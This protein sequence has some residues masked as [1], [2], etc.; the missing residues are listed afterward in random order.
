MSLLVTSQM[1]ELFLN[2][3]TADDKYSLHNIENLQ[4]PIQLH[5]SKKQKTFANFFSPI[6]KLTSNFE[7]FETKDDAHRLCIFEIMDCKRRC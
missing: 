1:L 4:Q 3:L 7:H 2:T 5:L 6:L